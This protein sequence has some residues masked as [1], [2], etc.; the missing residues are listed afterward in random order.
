LLEE[1]LI[2]VVAFLIE[3]EKLK[4]ILVAYVI[5]ER[6]RQQLGIVTHKIVTWRQGLYLLAE[7]SEP[8][9]AAFGLACP[10]INET[11]EECAA[12][13]PKGPCNEDENRVFN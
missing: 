13:T 10:D 9:P 1:G 12:Q 5:V 3:Q 2:E 4:L 8:F 6:P 7:V 11:L